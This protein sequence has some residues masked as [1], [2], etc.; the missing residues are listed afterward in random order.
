MGKVGKAVP[1][2]VREERREAS[3][4]ADPA[5]CERREVEHLLR[6]CCAVV[7]VPRRDERALHGGVSG[8]MLHAASS[9]GLH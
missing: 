9:C 4:R 5:G 6:D 8:C 7:H 3:S 2:H 1:D